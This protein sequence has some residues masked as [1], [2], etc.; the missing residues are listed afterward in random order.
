MKIK[1]IVVTSVKRSNH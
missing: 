1:T